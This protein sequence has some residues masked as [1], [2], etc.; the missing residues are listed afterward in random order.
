MIYNAVSSK[1]IISKVYRDANI[2][3]STFEYDAI[4]WIGEALDFIGSGMQLVKKEVWGVVE[5]HKCKLPDD[6]AFLRTVFVVNNAPLKENWESEE[7]P[8]D[9]EKVKNLKKHILPRQNNL[10]TDALGE[11]STDIVQKDYYENDD[12]DLYDNVKTFKSGVTR[13]QQEHY[14]LNPNYIH[15]TFETGLVLFAYKAFPVDEDGWPLVPDDSAF[16]E[17]LT[18][19]ILQ[20]LIMRGQYNNKQI[21]YEIAHQMWLKYCTQARNRA[22]FP[23]LDGMEELLQ[24]WT[25]MVNLQHFNKSNLRDQIQD[26]REGI[27]SGPTVDYRVT[28]NGVTRITESESIREV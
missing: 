2:D 8:Y 1:Y 19:Y 14:V 27:P 21:N 24:S 7:F 18:W 20:K 9:L 15:T 23:D 10:N 12:E 3:F 6:L 17:A 28:E 22:T 4:E 25:R 16:K 11:P 13:T 5:S 26:G